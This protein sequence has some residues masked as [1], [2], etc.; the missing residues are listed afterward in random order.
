MAATGEEAGEPA[1][2]F[3][4]IAVTLEDEL[5]TMVATLGARIEVA[6]LMAMGVVVGSLL[7][8]LYLPILG[9]SNA[10]GEGFGQ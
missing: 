5:D 4:N 7:V 1:M 2:M 8:V 9:L 6:L 3:E 10:V